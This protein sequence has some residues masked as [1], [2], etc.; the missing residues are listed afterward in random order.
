M[1]LNIIAEI[2]FGHNRVFGGGLRQDQVELDK[3]RKGDEGA[4]RTIEAAGR[5]AGLPFSRFAFGRTFCF[6]AALV[7][8]GRDL[9]RART[10]RSQIHRAGEQDGD[11]D[12]YY[13]SCELSHDI[14]IA[15]ISTISVVCYNSFPVVQ[16]PLARP[17][18]GCAWIRRRETRHG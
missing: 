8:S 2:I 5:A 7:V 15:N 12:E 9:L 10:D 1:R 4:K 16:A 14:K 11:G 3:G 6:V 17:G 18:D 13:E